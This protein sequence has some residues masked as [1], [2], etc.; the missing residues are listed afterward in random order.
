MSLNSLTPND[1]QIMIIDICSRIYSSLADEQI[2]DDIMS[3]WLSDNVQDYI[4]DEMYEPEY[5]KVQIAIVTEAV[6]KEFGL[7][8]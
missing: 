8:W 6:E 4:D 5:N 1:L 2:Y 7:I 3:D